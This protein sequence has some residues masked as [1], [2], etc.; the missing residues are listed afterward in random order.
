MEQLLYLTKYSAVIK[1]LWLFLLFPRFSSCIL[2]LCYLYVLYTQLYIMCTW[3]CIL[4][5][6]MLIS[7]PLRASYSPDMGMFMNIQ[8]FPVS[9]WYKECFPIISDWLIKRSL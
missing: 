3:S 6:Q 1:K 4:C 5:I 8:G 9:M 2:K 7:V